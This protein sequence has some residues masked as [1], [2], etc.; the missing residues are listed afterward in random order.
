MHPF[1]SISFGFFWVVPTLLNWFAK[2]IH[3]YP[4]TVLIYAE[5]I[6]VKITLS[7]VIVCYTVSQKVD[8]FLI[9][10]K[11]LTKINL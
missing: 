5:I 11:K 1:R 9:Y 7:I 8:V 3:L 2:H 10:V 4:G 6:S